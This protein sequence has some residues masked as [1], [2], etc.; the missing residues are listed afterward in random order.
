MGGLVSRAY[1]QSDVYGNDVAHLVTLGSPHWGAAKSYPYWEAANF[2]QS[3][4]I[5]R[6]AFSTLLEYYMIRQ[7]N[8]IPVNTLREVIPSFRDILYTSD[9]LYDEQNGDQ[10]KPEAEMFHRNTYLAGLNVGLDTLYARTD[11]STFAGQNLNTAARFYVYDRAWWQWPNWDDGVPNWSRALEFMSSGGDGTVLASSAEL[12]LPAHVQE[13]S[14]VSHGDLPGNS[15]VINAIFSALGISAQAVSQK[16]VQT[17]QGGQQVI[18]LVVDGAADATVTDPLGR[19]VGPGETSIPGAEYI[20]DP[21]DPFKL[22]LIPNPEDG[23][24]SIDVH[25]LYS[26]TYAVGLLDSFSSSTAVITDVL[27]LWDTS[28]SQIEPSAEVSFAL[29]YTLATSPTTS[30][31]AVTPVIETPVW[32][33]SVTVQGRALPGQFV[34][35]RDADTNTL[36]GN[37]YADEN[38]HYTITLLTPLVIGKRIYPWVNGEAGIPVDVKALTYLPLIIRK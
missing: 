34:E 5:E 14:G 20:S 35:I 12:P 36:L 6:I 8:P 32:A 3:D 27:A 24:F 13:F 2:Y 4:L 28:Q 7:I 33:G 16:S 10:V 25:G 11:V 37:G 18:V 9:Y 21:N 31:I 22:I 23:T 29:T 1:I 17:A 19:P 26:G 15:D 30:L 38:G